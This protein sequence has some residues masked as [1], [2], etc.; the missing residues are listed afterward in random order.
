MSKVCSFSLVISLK[1]K[2]R[3]TTGTQKG[4]IILTSYQVC[5][6]GD[7]PPLTHFSKEGGFRGLAPQVIQNFAS[8]RNLSIDFVLT[9]W[10]E[11]QNYLE[12]KCVLAAGGITWTEERA[13]QFIA[14]VPIEA[15][16]KIPVFA[17]RNAPLFQDFKDFNQ[18]DVIIVE[19]HGGTN[20]KYARTLFEKGLMTKP[21][22]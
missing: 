5:T 20:E 16:R 6:A 7:Y 13:K 9:P 3:I 11:L 1:L 4:T 12:T 15:D 18:P 19:N 8:S 2:G 10:A 22:F 21:S 17:S 14:S